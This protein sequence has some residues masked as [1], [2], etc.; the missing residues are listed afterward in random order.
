M[1]GEEGHGS[2]SCHQQADDYQE[3]H[4]PGSVLGVDHSLW[5]LAAAMLQPGQAVANE[6]GKPESED[7]FR[8]QVLDVEEV[9]HFGSR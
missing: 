8:K 6:Q 9:G 1:L 3:N 5:R 7:Q 4:S 2:P